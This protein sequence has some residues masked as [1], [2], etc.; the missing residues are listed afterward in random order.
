MASVSR[1]WQSGRKALSEFWGKSFRPWLIRRNLP[2]FVLLALVA[3]L[4]T[5]SI[6]RRR[7]VAKVTTPAETAVSLHAAESPIRLG[8]SPAE[9]A[10]A[11]EQMVRLRE[12]TAAAA[13]ERADPS[14]F[15]PP[16]RG[17]V[18]HGRG[19][20]RDKPGGVWV[21][22]RGIDLEVAPGLSVSAI[23]AGK[24]IRV[25]VDEEGGNLVEIDHGQG[26]R[27]VYGRLG[28]VLVEPDQEVA[29]GGM[30]GQP[31]A[32]QVHFELWQGKAA[33]DPL[34]VIPGL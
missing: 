2:Y 15:V 34:T 22:H 28:K 13:A 7:P 33:V 8:Q 31:I 25:G 18:L 5:T 9:V 17:R 30:L 1:F 24:V 14:T 21:Y 3:F 16:C 29:G 32:D 4:V 19:W 12:T 11:W 23:A 26:W 10:A 6:T 27:A 20:R